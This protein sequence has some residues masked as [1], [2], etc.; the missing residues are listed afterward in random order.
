ML[1]LKIPP[2]VYLL[3]FASL[4]YLLASYLPLW[5]LFSA[6]ITKIAY[7]FIVLGILFDLS[8]VGQFLRSRTTV[9]PIKPKNTNNI[10]STGM[11]RISRNPMYLGMLFLLTGWAFHLAVLAPFLLLPVFVMVLTVQQII[12]EE[13]IL[14][15]KF[16][17]NYLDY[18]QQ[19]RR[20]I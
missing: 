8:A 2:P 10:V 3:I 14:A 5:S 6:P 11:Y 19:V 16:G 18:K 15:R 1:K 7:V 17:K 4:M 13:E 9:N 20:W 12:P